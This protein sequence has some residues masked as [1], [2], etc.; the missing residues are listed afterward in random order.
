M[1]M[2]LKSN[3]N[4]PLGGTGGP[5]L[6]RNHRLGHKQIKMNMGMVGKDENVQWILLI[7]F[8]FTSSI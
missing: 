1:E 4:P 6:R 7:P 3:F 8:Y 2:L 5:K